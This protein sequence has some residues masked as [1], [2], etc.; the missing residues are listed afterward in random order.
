M[1]FSF[2]NAPTTETQQVGFL[3]APEFSMLCLSSAIEPLRAANRTAGTTLYQR[4]LF[5]ISGPKVTA[6]NG[7]G[8][9]VD[10]P[11]SADEH[12]PLLVVCS[13]FNPDRYW[14]AELANILRRLRSRGT[15]FCGLDT[16]SIIL[17]KCGL[18][19]DYKATIH[20]EMLGS[21]AE[22]FPKIDVV[23]DRF[24]VDR[25]RMTAGGGTTALDLM[26]A[27]IRAQHGHFLAFDVASQFIYEHERLGSDPQSGIAIRQ[28]ARQAPALAIALELMENS[29][30]EPL[31]VQDIARRAGV[32]QKEL[33]RLFQRHMKIPPGRYYRNLRLTIA[34]RM[35]YK[36]SLSIAEVSIRSGFSSSSAFIRSY[37]TRYGHPPGSQRH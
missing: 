34:Q 10:G 4:T 28:L 30:E 15:A 13:S 19:D 16:G 22:E 8:I 9:D 1:L 21:F 31:S 36:T 25:G 2:S 17:A 3:L 27:L 6:S 14:S 7:L 29:I 12:I 32:R 35:L 18:L 5:S 23:P 11:L 37:K 24:V 33:E 26:L 20:W